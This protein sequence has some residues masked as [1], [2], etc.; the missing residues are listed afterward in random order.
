MITTFADLTAWVE[1]HY[2][3]RTAESWDRVGVVCGAPEDPV[4]R[5]LVTVD[6]TPA[7]VEEAIAGGAQAI[8]AHHPLLLRG[9]HGVDART[10]KG[11]MVHRLIRA[12]VGLIAAHTNADVAVGG[13]ADAMARVIGLRDT[14]PLAPADGPALD[15]VVTFVPTTHTGAVVDALAAAGAGAIGDYER[16]CFRHP[17]TGSFRPLEGADPYLGSVGEVA[18][19][20][21]ERVEMVLPRSRR[22]AVIAALVA[23]HPYEE[24]AYHVLELAPGPAA[25][26]LGR[27]GRLAGPMSA[28][29]FCAHVAE[30]LP[31][32]VGGVRMAGDPDRAVRVV[33]L[34]PGAGDSLLD[35]A[36]RARHPR[37]AAGERVDA[38]VTS[39]LR[40]HPAA[41]FIEH[42]A[43]P[44]LVD[45]A[46]WSAESTWLPLLA[47]QLDAAGVAA[48][49]SAVRTD[50]WT[51]RV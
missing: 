48:R 12:G 41:E 27:V 33:A 35:A 9:V 37:G 1:Q 19:V 14:E 18:E 21:E 30:V 15:Q 28:A 31:R 36:R 5:V 2:P 49:V 45:V 42:D 6:V 32:T 50:P 16:C 24:P 46:H 13:V 43:S 40:H 11:R 38:Y 4:R 51:L 7:V 3:P 34:L 44:V 26:G 20:A 25:T 22:A 23:A 39:D 17:G 29:A 47:E 8:I 10:P